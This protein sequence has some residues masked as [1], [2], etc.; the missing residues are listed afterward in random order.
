MGS[1]FIPQIPTY[2]IEKAIDLEGISG[3]E[4]N[5]LEHPI[6]RKD[7]AR[8]IYSFNPNNISFKELVNFGVSSK[9]AFNWT[10]YLEKGGR[11]KSL[12]DVKRVYGLSTE[13]LTM[14][15]P[16]IQFSLAP[17]ADKKKETPALKK[18]ATPIDINAAEYGD[19]ISI[20]MPSSVAHVLLK[21][22]MAGK[23]FY[24]MEELRKVYGLT[25]SLLAELAPFL[26]FADRPAS[27]L[28]EPTFSNLQIDLNNTDTVELKKL[29][30]I[31]SKLA[32]R[33][34]KYRDNLGG[35]YELDQ[36]KEIYGLPDSTFQFIKPNLYI[37][38]AIKTIQV[39]TT[40][41]T[42]LYHPYFDKKQASI[43][44]NFIAAH[45]PIRSLEQL[46]DIRAFNTDFWKK[47]SP[48]LDFEKEN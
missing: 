48:Y 32:Q 1:F 30:G 2:R 28:K 38:S 44:Q 40:D 23:V 29:T 37:S 17:Q 36:L 33:I 15:S 7:H 20:G 35:F 10:K 3:V 41:F 34:L 12:N 43:I 19:L 46:Y 45:K 8:S 16:F 9:A 4:V 18:V 42:K 21:Y 11:F 14:L 6:V 24:N 22:R 13:Q 26:L 25:D 5:G 47:L 31:G 39:N 27:V